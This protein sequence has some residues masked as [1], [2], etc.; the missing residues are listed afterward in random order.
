MTSGTDT[1]PPGAARTVV[2]KIG[3]SSVTAAGGGVDGAAIERVSGDIAQVRGAGHS[4]VLVSSG[5]IAAGW[6]ALSGGPRPTDPA[7][8]RAAFS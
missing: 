5:A 3:S 4:V 1:A 7:T 8:L 6:A 2:A